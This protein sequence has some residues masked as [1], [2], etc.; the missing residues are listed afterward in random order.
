[1]MAA[2]E[3]R[4]LEPKSTMLP[5]VLEAWFLGIQEIHW[6]QDGLMTKYNFDILRILIFF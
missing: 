3:L 5:I 1:M 2:F 4:L 6:S